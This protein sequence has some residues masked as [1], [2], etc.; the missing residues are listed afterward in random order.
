ME[1]KEIERLKF[2]RQYLLTSEAITCPFVH[3]VRKITDKYYL[4]TH[5]DLK[6]TQLEKTDVKLILLGDAF[7]YLEPS[8]DNLAILNDLIKHNFDNILERTAKYCG[9]FVILCIK[10]DCFR[11]FHDAMASRKVYYGKVNENTWMASQPNLLAQTLGILPTTDNEKLEYYHSPELEGRYGANICESTLYDEILQLL[12]NHYLDVNL[13][14]VNRYWPHRVNKSARVQD[15]AEKCGKM[16]KGYMEAIAYRYEVML[17]L[18]AGKDSRSLLAAS[19]GF[20]DK[21]YCY[22]NKER[23]LENSSP[24]IQIPKKLMEALNMDFHIIDP[25]IPVD[26]DFRKVY[27]ENNPLASEIFLPIIYNY[28]KNHS[29][30]V[31]LPGNSVTGGLE[32]YL[33]SGDD[34]DSDGLVNSDELMDLE[35]LK[36]FNFARTLHNKWLLGAKE[37]CVKNHIPLLALFY[38]E[39]RLTNVLLQVQLDKDMAQEEFCP[40]NSRELISTLLS[41]K[42]EDHFRPRYLIY[43]KIMQYLWPELLK[44]P[45]NSSFKSHLIGT[46][47][48]LK[49]VNILCKIRYRFNHFI[50]LFKLRG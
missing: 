19:F 31:N 24:D 18:T 45:I 3:D 2:R 49:L 20:R 29:Q 11:V 22:I 27:N 50:S 26:E 9:R 17:P 8:N 13:G 25:Y 35:C 36:H 12:P 48:Y 44:L 7:D 23:K 46:I 21:L 30:K 40:F 10:S 39:N 43:R 47:T 34:M 14:K 37:P 16:L 15:I 1:K 42:K 33:V 38:W 5:I 41:T 32:Y 28:Y 4:Y 6:V